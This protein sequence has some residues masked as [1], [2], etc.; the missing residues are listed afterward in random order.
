MNYALCRAFGAV[1][2]PK[3]VMHLPKQLKNMSAWILTI[4]VIYVI[5]AA[6]TRSSEDN[7][8]TYSDLV[9][10]IRQEQVVSLTID[11]SLTAT[12]ELLQTDSEKTIKVKT[13]IPSLDMLQNA[14]G[15][16][17]SDQIES[18]K[19]VM[20][21]DHSSFPLATVLNLAMTAAVLVVLVI[22]MTRR[23]GGANVFTKTHAKIVDENNNK[24]KFKNVAGAEEEKAE[25][26]EVVEFLKNPAKF[27]ALGARIPKGLL[28][29]GPPGTGK[30]LLAKATAGEAGVPFYS[31]SG[32]DFVELY[33]GVGAG[34][35][36]DLF[37]Q[38]KKTK[39]CI[40]F[41][42]EIDAVG[43]QRGAGMGGGHDEREQTLN[44][45]LVEM[46]GFGENEGVIV[47]AATNR[48]D[49]LDKALL[50]PGR[51]DRQIVVDLPDVGGRLDILKVHSANKPIA[52]SVDLEKVA[53]STTG[54]TGADLE[55]LM[56]EAAIFAARRNHV[57]IVTE[58]IEDANIKVMMGAEKRSRMITDD[59]RKLTAYHEAG[60]AVL[61]RLIDKTSAVQQVSIIPR[62]RA[63]GYTMYLPE[64][65]KMYMSKTEMLN[66]IS[67]LL[68]GRV[69][70]ELTMDDVSTG[71]S[72]DLQRATDIARKMVTQYGMSKLGA[73][74]YDNG[75]EVFVGRDYGHAK[76]YSDKVAA[77]I[78]EEIRAIIDERYSSAKKMLCDNMHIL[79][80]VAEKLLVQETINGDEFEQCFVNSMEL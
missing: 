57:E 71:A 25:I 4:A 78:D 17:L 2:K 9:N 61:A 31:I 74:C 51:F 8:F 66:K 7:S 18:G 16:D 70:E 45:L 46:D 28:L 26:E 49:I 48:P 1:E 29:V 76:S 43:R 44:Q 40:I 33:V 13:E 21:A 38:A 69:A 77:E 75:G 80:S 63:G 15:D 32:S 79:K 41:I 35:V 55:N 36:R 37:E 19:L 27:T 12:A 47:I 23:T 20:E 53:R 6:M 62:G 65:D 30:T 73:I 52:K 68:G 14:V 54:Y 67:V 42:D 5:F 56:N 50:R 58:D 11:D 39:P 24:I 3:G 64:D 60:H 10:A 72:N 59:E 34:R 22:F